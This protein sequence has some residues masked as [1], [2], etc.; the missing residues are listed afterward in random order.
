MKKLI[1]VMSLLAFLG[2]SLTATAKANKRH[3][4]TK[5]KM[6][7]GGSEEETTK[8]AEPAKPAKKAHK[9]AKAKPK[10]KEASAEAAPAAAAPAA[11]PAEKK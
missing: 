3:W 5:T 7:V 8:A 1:A 10:K 2:L 11:A 4:D 6:Y 9:K